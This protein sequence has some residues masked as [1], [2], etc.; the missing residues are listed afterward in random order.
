M[1]T[2]QIAL[3]QS[4]PDQ[5]PRPAFRMIESSLGR[6]Q[7]NL[8]DSSRTEKRLPR[9]TLSLMK[10]TRAAAVGEGALERRWASSRRR[11]SSAL[12]ALRVVKII[13]RDWDFGWEARNSSARRQHIEN[14]RPLRG[15]RVST[16]Y[17]GARGSI[18]G[19]TCLLLLPGYTACLLPREGSPYP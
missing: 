11:V 16:R 14:P 10:W 6:V 18:G 17:L 19:A 2:P 13:V 8:R 5:P 15:V 4:I 1:H 12:R 9:S 7:I 3:G